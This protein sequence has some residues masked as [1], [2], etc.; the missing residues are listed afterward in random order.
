MHMSDLNPTGPADQQQPLSQ[1]E[2]ETAFLTSPTDTAFEEQRER[3]RV[4]MDRG[5]VVVLLIGAITLLAALIN[6]LRGNAAVAHWIFPVV[7]VGAAIG[8]YYGAERM[9]NRPARAVEVPADLAPVLNDITIARGE[10]VATAP[11]V[12]NPEELS[13]VLSDAQERHKAAFD[14]ASETLRAIRAQDMTRASQ[15]GTEVYRHA[16]VIEQMRDDLQ[17]DWESASAFSEGYIGETAAEGPVDGPTGPAYAPRRVQEPGYPAEPAYPAQ[18]ANYPPPPQASGYAA[19]PAGR[20]TAAGPNPEA[21]RSFW[22]RPAGQAAPPTS[23][24]SP[25]AE[26]SPAETGQTV[27]ESP[28]PGGHRIQRDD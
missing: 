26:N 17:R 24:Q 28:Q 10:V 20:A 9:S 21:T 14:A 15:L 16:D 11:R 13:Q 1:F 2:V 27:E 7:A 23:P 12:L 4:L 8:L 18:P 19:R 25:S 3:L 6:A 22:S 5:A